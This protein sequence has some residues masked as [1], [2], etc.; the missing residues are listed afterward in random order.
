MDERNRVIGNLRWSG[1][2]I[3]RT[4]RM[5]VRRKAALVSTLAVAVSLAEIKDAANRLL[6]ALQRSLNGEGGA[7]RS[8]PHVGSGR[9]VSW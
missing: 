5:H 8:A 9:K 6:P 1:A 7:N 4:V 3:V 2:D